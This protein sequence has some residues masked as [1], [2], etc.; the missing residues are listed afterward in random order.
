MTISGFVAG[1]LVH[2]DKGLV[3]IEQLKVGDM[4][5]SK[6]ESGD[7]LTKYSKIECITSK[8]DQQILALIYI[9]DESNN[10]NDAGTLC[11]DILTGDHSVWVNKIH[12]DDDSP[13]DRNL[14]WVDAN[15]IVPSSEFS[16]HDGA[17]GFVSYVHSVYQA[18]DEDIFWLNGY[19]GA[20]YLI[21]LKNNQ[22]KIYY[23]AHL[24]D[25]MVW[26]DDLLSFDNDIEIGD[27]ANP[28]I[29][30]FYDFFINRLDDFFATREIYNI[31]LEDSETYYIGRAGLLTHS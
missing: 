29:K 4:V 22:K 14:G 8:L 6:H 17:F 1:T 27:L 13:F 5:L 15:N 11:I 23:I 24:F 16:F 10:S 25:G 19:H 26:R 28:I 31:K 18:P 3:P 20:E 2:T 30:D 7:S 12:A 9:Y 21:D